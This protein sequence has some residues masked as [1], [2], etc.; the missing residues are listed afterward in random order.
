MTKINDSTPKGL[1]S[2]HNPV[3]NAY[4]LR[5]TEPKKV[6]P[7]QPKLCGIKESII[8]KEMP[9]TSWMSEEIDANVKERIDSLLHKKFIPCGDP[10][11]HVPNCY[12]TILWVLGIDPANMPSAYALFGNNRWDQCDEHPHR[13][14]N[15]GETMMRFLELSGYKNKGTHQVITPGETPQ[16]VCFLNRS[17]EQRCTIMGENRE[18]V[19]DYSAFKHLKVGDVIIFSGYDDPAHPS[20]AALVVDITPDGKPLIFHKP[21]Y[22][23][24]PISKFEVKH[25]S[26]HLDGYGMQGDQA[27]EQSHI[28]IFRRGD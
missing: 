16:T 21:S 19:R 12:G 4:E 15:R 22:N 8:K 14:R 11:Q 28:T 9:R 24:G 27:E 2:V 13:K 26:E 20:H 3:E 25:L 1:A 10:D 7:D 5:Q 6:D 23:C 17:E 18:A